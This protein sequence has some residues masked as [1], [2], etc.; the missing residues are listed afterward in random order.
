MQRHIGVDAFDH[1]LGQ[2]RAH[3]GQ[4]LLARVAVHDDLADHRVVVGRHKVVGVSVRIH[5]HTGAAWRVPGGDATGGRNEL[6]R[7]FRIHP[8]LDGV[9]TDLDLALGEGQLF[10]SRHHDLRLHDVH[11]RDQLGH[12]VLHL[13]AGVHFNEIELAVFVQELERARTAVADLLAGRNAALADLLD[14][15]ARNAG[16]WRLFNDLL[17]A[18][19]HGAVALA[20]VHRVA[21]LVG[22]DL[23]FDVAGVLEKLLHVHRRIAKRGTRFG[24]GHL[25]RVDQGSLGVHHAHATATTATGGLDDD[26]IADGLGDAADLHRVVGQLAFRAGHAGH[27]GTD[28]GLL[29]RHLV[30]HDADG[31]GCGADELETALFHALGE[32]GVFAQE[33]IAGVDGFRIGHLGGRDDGRHVEV[34]QGR[35]GGPDAHGLFG[36]LDVFRI[37]VGFGIDHDGLDSQLAACALDTQSDLSAVRNQNFLEHERLIR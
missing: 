27:A 10:A 29:G 21:M 31:L 36:Q 20:Q 34:A 14:Q 24:L 4:S 16:R 12:R 35:R 6:V 11:A 2:R 8:A 18:A 25:H 7:V 15:L 28:H 30:T 17:V 5:T 23:D 13:H 19:L 22:Q 9:A 32:V 26:R 3:A 1:R 33:T 37:A